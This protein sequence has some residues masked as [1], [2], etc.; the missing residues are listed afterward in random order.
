MFHQRSSKKTSQ[1]NKLHFT[2]RYSTENSDRPTIVRLQFVNFVL[3][4][5]HEYGVWVVTR[6]GGD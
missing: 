1:L 2:S 4:Y 3:V 5:D 6:W